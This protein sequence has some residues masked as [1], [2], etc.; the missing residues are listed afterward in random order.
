MS[1]PC[2]TALY[3]EM[4]PSFWT[5]FSKKFWEK[6]PAVFKNLP[7]SI[8]SSDEVFLLLVR[9]ADN[10][11]RLKDPRGYKL[12]IDG[13][14]VHDE[15]LLELLPV[16]KDRSLEGYHRRMNSM[17]ED[18]C[19]VCDELLQVYQG[20]KLAHFSRQL[21]QN[22]GHP[23][24]FA[25]VG[26]YLG[27]YRKT[28]FGVHV[29]GCGVFS[30]PIEGKKTFRTWSG[31]FG[32]KHPELDRTFNYSKFIKNSRVLQGKPGDM[33][34]WP[35][36]EWHI[37][38]A[39]GK[40]TA[41][42]SLGIWV[43]QSIEILALRALK[44]LFQS[45]KGKLKNSGTVFANQFSS[46]RG[47]ILQLPSAI[48]DLMRVWQ[49]V[50]QE[51]IQ[52]AFADEWLGLISNQGFKPNSIESRTQ[53]TSL[54]MDSS[55]ALVRRSFPILWRPIASTKKVRCAF[56]GAT[57]VASKEMAKLFAQLNSG[58][59]CRLGDFFTKKLSQEDQSTLQS[60]L[61][62]GALQKNKSC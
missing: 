55:F 12:F 48:K 57:F 61:K 14:Q 34:Y 15:E 58:K 41:T 40:F 62:A 37:A 13:V 10:C 25:E 32:R 30:F 50:S 6:K 23:V 18:Y 38:E 4:N 46:D 11:R 59:T 21:F 2:D 36:S 22:V 8:L 26:L 44:N 16:R 39:D 33:I 43:D 53:I 20:E 1:S 49:S 52:E 45:K 60:L 28:P 5:Q 47:E 56:G 19:L 35:S 3:M 42:W 29:D 27:N 7:D 31:S 51:E 54:N 17:F 24:R 9:F